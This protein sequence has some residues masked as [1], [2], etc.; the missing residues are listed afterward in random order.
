MSATVSQAS[1]SEI[2]HSKTSQRIMGTGFIIGLVLIGLF[3]FTALMGLLGYADDLRD[4]NNGGAHAYSTSAVGFSGLKLLLEN[5]DA[6]LELDSNKPS[7]GKF[8]ALRIYT[9]GSAYQT[10][11][12]DEIEAG[13]PKLII[14]PKWNV[15]PAPKTAG[16]VRKIHDRDLQRAEPLASNLE[17]LAGDIKFDRIGKTGGDLAKEFTFT[18]NGTSATYTDY[19]PRLQTISG[20]NLLPVVKTQSDTIVLAQIK[21]TNSYILSDP[22]FMNTHGLSSKMRAEFSMNILN[23]LMLDS[24]A[25][26]L[27]I[28]LSIHGIGGGQ[29]MVKLFTQPPFL[30]VT[31]LIFALIGLLAWQ[32]FLRFG[33]P[34]KGASEDFGEDFAMGPQSLAKTTA[35][36]LSIARREPG[37]MADYSALIR[38]QALSELRAKGRAGTVPDAILDKREALKKLNPPFRTLDKRARNITRRDEMADMAKALQ[39]WK[40]DITE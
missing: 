36:F 40:K 12:L 27:V 22:D 25:N 6:D 1:P 19:F 29:N 9:L 23:Y 11:G 32:A 8:T 35:E 16:W 30:S 20:D 7:Y 31:I 21:D 3:S 34:Q 10:D 38:K 33:D 17:A 28:D 39:T 18:L 37:V 2:G 15:V 13:V 5:L 24:G 14:L 4:R 26:R